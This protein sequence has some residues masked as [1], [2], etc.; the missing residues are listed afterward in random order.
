VTAVT[1]FLAKARNTPPVKHEGK[2]RLIFAMDATMSRQPT[3]DRA[4]SIQAEMFEAAEG[5]EVQL[6][7]FRGFHEC[8]AS[9]WVADTKSLARLMTKVD[10]R[11]GNT[12]IGRVMSHALDMK[13]QGAKAV[14]F[15]GDAME[16]NADHLCDLAGK[17]GLVGLPFFMFQEGSNRAATEAFKEIARLSKGV[18]VQLTGTSAAMLR[19][20]LGAAAAYANGGYAAL[21]AQAGAG[22]KGAASLL[23]KLSGA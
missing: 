19:E 22:R 8:Q 2:G 23:Q 11:G 16:E 5:L 18:H 10:C 17:A 4:L 13:G 3:W 15:V 7:Y 12:Q 20:L 9:K 6:V 1:E 21:E 14:V